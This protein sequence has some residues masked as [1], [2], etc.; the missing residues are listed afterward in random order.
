MI[1]LLPYKL[2][3]QNPLNHYT[4]LIANYICKTNNRWFSYVANEYLFGNEN[5]A[6]VNFNRNNS[7]FLGLMGL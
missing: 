2:L 5:K 7:N 1:F 3:N 6:F 4:V